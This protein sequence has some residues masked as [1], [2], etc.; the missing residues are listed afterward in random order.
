[1]TIAAFEPK[2]FEER[3]AVLN[4]EDLECFRRKTAL[5][6][7]L[8]A[9]ARKY[10]DCP[11]NKWP[12]LIF[13]WDLNSESQCLSLDGVKPADFNCQYPEGF[14]LGWVDF[15]EF[16]AKLCHFSRRDGNEELWALGRKSN[17][18]YVIAYLAKGF[19][20]TPPLVGINS[21]REL[22][23]CGGHHR[24]AAAKATQCI[25]ILPIYFEASNYDAI[26]NIVAVQHNGPTPCVAENVPQICGASPYT[27]N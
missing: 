13:N 20:M 11:P 25:E 26:N 19:P 6:T 10:I 21:T 9:E 24:Y 7:E 22:C 17:L 23:L 4:G 16:D 5:R 8:S 18:A 12:P 3:L 1:M 14:Q 2:T 15:A 27:K